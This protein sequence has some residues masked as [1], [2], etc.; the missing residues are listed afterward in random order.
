MKHILLSTALAFS[1]ILP[2][3][4]SQAATV[5]TGDLI[6]GSLSSVYYIGA[7]GARY[8]FPTEKIYFTWYTDFS[9]VKTVTNAE[10]ASYPIGGNV[11]YRP[12]VRM[13][14]IMTD[15]RVYAVDAG[16][17]LRWVETE[18]MATSLYGSDWNTKIDDIS[19]AYFTNYTLGSSITTPSEFDVSAITTNITS[20][21]SDK[22]LVVPGIPEPSPTPTPEPVVASGTLTASKTSA[23]VNASIDLFASATLNSGLS[24]IRV[25][26]NGILEKTCTSSPCNVSV[27]IPSSPDVS[28]AVAEFSWTNGATASA[29]KGVTLDTSGQSGVRI[30]VTR[31][32]IR[33]GGILEITSEVD[34]NIATKYLEIYLDENLIRSCTDL[35]ICQYADT[36]SSPTGTIH[37]VYAIARDILGNTY[38]SASQE[39]RVVDN[40]HPYTTIALGKTLI[41]SGET[42][43]ATVQAS[44][45]DGIAST[46]IW[47]N[48]SL[49]KE[50]LS[51]I[52]TAN[53]GPITTPG[54]YAIV[55]K[56]KDLTGL[57]TV[58]TSESFLV[59]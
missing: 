1:I 16:G 35:R 11:T 42:I 47:F 54:F 3:F 12:G 32:E 43:D 17:T 26:W 2:P 21:S 39:V 25:L 55:G 40:P 41:Y 36:D 22:G 48:N 13:V 7:D 45:D 18:E 57:E 37:E 34:Q 29:T 52:C 5:Q 31:P 4:V 46:Q 53:V 30:V 8:V 51:S 27:T 44:D 28:T 14:K 19:D 58:V 59:Q 23:T 9:S 20:I 38:Q 10:L 24:Q 50:C 56:A 6:R 33:S 49:V 15:P